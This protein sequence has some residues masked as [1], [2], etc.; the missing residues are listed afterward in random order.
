MTWIPIALLAALLN[1]LM[2]FF[3]KLSSNKING[4]LGG[5]ILNSAAVIPVLIY[6]LYQKSQGDILITKPGI[7]YSIIA[8]LSIGT[9]TIFL[10]RL[11]S[12]GGNLSLISP[13]LRITIGVFS[14]ILGLIIFRETLT[15]KTILGI[16]LAA[17][18]LYLMVTG[19]A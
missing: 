10:F 19:K 13:F 15:T 18:G 11:F 5:I 6:F 16:L 12:M 3:V 9:A 8:G 1:T 17:S 14:I 7:I 4:P 2:D